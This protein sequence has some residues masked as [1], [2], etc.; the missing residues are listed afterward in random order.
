MRHMVIISILIIV[1]YFY[2]MRTEVTEVRAADGNEY[3]VINLPNNDIASNLLSEIHQRITKLTTYL[4]NNID[5]YPEY[6]EYITLLHNNTQNM[7]ISENS[8]NNKY[9]SYTVDKGKEMVFC[10]RSKDTHQFHDIN[11][12]MFV[13]IHELAHTACPEKNHTPLFVRIFVFLLKVAMDLKLYVYENYT[14]HPVE[15]C[16]MMLNETPIN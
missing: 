15:Y 13:T 12:L 4:W 10:L 6:S 9:T 2:F 16:G 7:K 11:L 3:S 5:K 8:P 14:K 1:L